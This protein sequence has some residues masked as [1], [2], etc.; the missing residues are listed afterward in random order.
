MSFLGDLPRTEKKLLVE[1]IGRNTY[2]R[3]MDDLAKIHN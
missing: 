1:N 2:Q 3:I